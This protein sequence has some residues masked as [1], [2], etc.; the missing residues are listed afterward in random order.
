MGFPEKKLQHLDLE[1]AQTISPSRIAARNS[2][3]SGGA[4]VIQFDMW[5][6]VFVEPKMPWTRFAQSAFLHIAA[7]ALIWTVSFSWLRQQKI[8]KPL[9]DRSSLVAYTPEE[10]L[11]KLDTGATKAPVTKGDPVYAKQPILS[12]PPEADNRA[13][14]IVVP[15]DVKLNHDVPLPNIVATGAVAPT[16][17]LDATQ[18]RSNRM[19]APDAA[20]VAPAPDVQSGPSRMRAELR[21]DVIAPP[22]EV[23]QARGRV[24][25]INIGQS[26][27]IAPAPQL[28]LAEQHSSSGRG[29]S[30]LATASMQ[31][32]AP[33]PTM[34]GTAS[35]GSANGR[36]VAL[37]I[38]PVVPTGP[39]VAPAGNRRGTF[40]AGPNGKAGAVG[41]PEVKGRSNAT[42]AGSLNARVGSL[43][44]GLR[45]GGEADASGNTSSA[46]SKSGARVAAAVPD[47]KIT[48]V[49][50]KVFGGRRV[51]GRTLNMPNL[52]SSSGSWVIKFAELEQGGN[53]KSPNSAGE[54]LEPVAMEKS[55][56]GYPLELMRSNVHGMVTLYAVIHSDG[57]VGEIRVLTSPDDRLDS[58]AAR[59]L[60]RWKFLP[61]ERAG[62]PVALEAVVEIPF[63][64]HQSF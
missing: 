2:L 34:G 45:V 53:V 18:L 19:L 1:A 39:V 3:H 58:Y 57:K 63:K 52:N 27:V 60:A 55:D 28:S 50:R 37:G 61:A 26:Q 4:R 36:L 46:N 35:S 51:Y 43:P 12:V 64:V 29:R 47:E 33:P 49:D 14:T 30:G 31:P 5:H 21:S 44:P 48:D 24:S 9:F 40:S 54:L 62:K 13:Q 17:P 10:Y 8:L 42:G 20:V 7:L 38:H 32:V 56:P 22:E 59:A 6:D 23:T 11:P 16:V 25:D 15:P 41:T